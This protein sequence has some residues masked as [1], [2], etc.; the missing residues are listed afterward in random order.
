MC[1]K[2]NNPIIQN[3]FPEIKSAVIEKFHYHSNKMKYIYRLLK[4]EN[5]FSIEEC[6]CQCMRLEQS[7]REKFLDII[8]HTAVI[9]LKKEFILKCG[10][11]TQYQL[12]AYKTMYITMDNIDLIMHT[13]EP[14]YDEVEQESLNKNSTSLNRSMISGWIL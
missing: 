12:N 3:H 9:L 1:V 8:S 10:K 4:T 11:I 14:D 13:Y 5:H 7:F 2:I 6:L